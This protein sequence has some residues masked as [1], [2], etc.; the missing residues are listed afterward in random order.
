VGQA[1]RIQGVNPADISLLLVHLERG[2]VSE[3]SN[4]VV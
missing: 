3:F 4:T 1:A 2:A